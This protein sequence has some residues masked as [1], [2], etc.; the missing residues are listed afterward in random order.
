MMIGFTPST[1]PVIVIQRIL[2]P[3]A[4]VVFLRRVM[5]L[6]TLYVY[7]PRGRLRLREAGMDSNTVPTILFSLSAD[8]DH[9]TDGR[10][11]HWSTLS[12][13]WRV[14]RRVPGLSATSLPPPGT[15]P[16]V[17]ETYAGW[18]PACRRLENALIRVVQ[19]L[20]PPR[21]PVIVLLRITTPSRP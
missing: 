18:N 1:P 12:S 10:P 11:S 2:R 19:H 20:P 5:T 21:R 6:P 9:T 3:R 17:I 16:V 8:S 14:T 7:G 13:L 4:R 15:H